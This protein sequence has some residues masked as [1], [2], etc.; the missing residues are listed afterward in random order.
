MVNRRLILLAFVVVSLP[1]AFAAPVFE[2]SDEVMHFAFVHHLAHGGGLPVQSLASKEAPWAQEGSQPPLYYALAAPVVRMFDTRDFDAQ[3]LPN[4][5][6]LYDPYAPGNKNVLIITPEKRAFAYRGTT[7]A[8]VALRLLGILPGCVTVWLAFGIAHLATGDRREAAV[9][10]ALTAFNPMFLTVTTAVS[11]DGLLIALT[12]TALYVLMRALAQGVTLPRAFAFGALA[13]LASLTKLSGALL[14]PLA[15]AML[16]APGREPPTTA[17]RLHRSKLIAA[18]ILPWLLIAGWWYARNVVLYGEPT[19]TAMMAAIAHPRRISFLEALAEFEGLRLSYL[20]VFGHFNVPADGLVYQA[21]DIFLLACLAGLILHLARRRR[22]MS[23][24]YWLRVGALAA[25]P[26]LTY[27][28]LVRWTMMTPASQGRLLFPGI[29]ALSALMAIGLTAL[30]QATFTIGQR[31]VVPFAALPAASCIGLLILAVIAPFR[32]VI[33]AYTPPLVAGLP[34]G[35]LPA[36]QRLGS[37]AEIVG[38]GVRPEDV[39][40]GEKV[41]VSVVMRAL[42]PTPG[43]YSLVVNLLGRDNRLLAR[44]DTFTG[45]GLLPSSQWR[46][47][48][49][50]RDTVE[51][52]IP[53]N[54]EAPAT[55]RVQF[56]LYNRGS[57]DIAPS[58]DDQGN[59]G[60]PVFDGATLLPASSSGEADNSAWI[61]ALGDIG[62]LQ[63]A[64]FAPSA[65]AGQPLTVMLT[66]RT[67]RPTPDAYTTFVHLVDERGTLRAQGDAPPLGG[68]FPTPRWRPGI[69]FDDS[70]TLLLPADLPPGRYRLFAGLYHAID[71]ARLP[72]FNPGGARLQDDRIYL[73]EVIVSSPTGPT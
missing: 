68:Q 11:N 38:Y 65:T 10:M 46:A 66:W 58:Y 64:R 12:T 23:A 3:R 27:A 55:L 37:F 2:K 49:M 72:A 5:S 17:L 6:P 13:G 57:G 69:T 25:Y 22:S 60:A 40:P 1:Y 50:W 39:R 44:F 54:A 51:L 34:D 19:G 41:R 59:P 7:L 20:A 48:Q 4:A 36:R 42:R 14:L 26:M 47:G 21:F 56:A 61:A 8:A 62:L 52:T 43:D 63:A 9:A 31:R 29:A 71:L 32:Y 28:A 15:G 16:I 24:A 73:G 35:M 53:R 33:P 45:G 18:V 67:L 30:A 70:Y